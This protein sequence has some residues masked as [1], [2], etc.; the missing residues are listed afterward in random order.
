MT[1]GKGACRL[2]FALIVSLPLCAAHIP[3]AN[4]GDA[5]T[6]LGRGVANIGGSWLELVH[7]TQHTY[8]QDGALAGATTGVVKGVF[9]T[10]YRA[11]VGVY[12]TATFLVPVPP[13]YQPIIYPEYVPLRTGYTQPEGRGP[14]PSGY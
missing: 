7:Q 3:P 5:M 9:M 10:A 2:V 13:D 14:Q 12:E 8:E 4:A 11:I 6:K 1:T